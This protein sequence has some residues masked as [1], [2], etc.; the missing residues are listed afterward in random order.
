MATMSGVRVPRGIGGRRQA[1]T[2]PSCRA[3]PVCALM[4]VHTS[5]TPMFSTIFIAMPA[6]RR[7]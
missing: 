2:A 1:L 6:T 3:V 7:R 5:D 4:P